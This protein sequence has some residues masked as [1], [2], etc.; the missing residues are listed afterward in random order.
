M[1]EYNNIT[2]ELQQDTD[3]QDN[4]H[5][6][7]EDVQFYCHNLALEAGWW[8]DIHT[9]ELKER[10]VG[11]AIALVHSELSEALEAYRKDL[12]DD[13]LTHRKGLEVELAD[14]IIRILDLAGGLGLDVG[15]ALVEKLLYNTKRKDHKIQERIKDG[16][17]AI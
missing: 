11:E 15:G 7:V 16:G 17:K 14:A 13:H 10:N 1:T 12:M 6:A 8:H 3:V 5:C 2:E 4:L 9:G